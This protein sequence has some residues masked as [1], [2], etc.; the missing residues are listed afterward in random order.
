MANQEQLTNNK[1]ENE[2]SV[3]AEAAAIAI[4]RKFKSQ[5]KAI[6]DLT[7]QVMALQE[8]IRYLEKRHG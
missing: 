8:K 1:E 4:I 5:D 2:V 3:T 7:A 6:E